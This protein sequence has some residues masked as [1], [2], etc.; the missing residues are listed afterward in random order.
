ME[1]GKTV[2]VTMADLNSRFDGISALVSGDE[3]AAY[4]VIIDGTNR[5]EIKVDATT[6]GGVQGFY[7]TV[8]AADAGK[9]IYFLTMS[10]KG[11][12]SY[13]N[14]TES[15]TVKEAS[16][17]PT[18]SPSPS[19]SPSPVDA[20]PPADTPTISSTS[21]YLSCY[22]NQG[23]AQADVAGYTY[24][25]G[26][27]LQVWANGQMAVDKELSYSSDMYVESVDIP[28]GQATDVS[29]RIK[30]GSKVS[31]WTTESVTP[32]PMEKPA[33]SVTKISAKKASL[34]WTQVGGATHYQIYQGSKLKKTVK[35]GSG[36]AAISGAKAGSAKYKIVP[37]VKNT[38]NPSPVKGPA[39]DTKKGASNQ[40]TFSINKNINSVSYGTNAPFRIS[41]VSLSGSTYTVTGYV[42]NN[43]MFKMTKYKSLKVDI[44]SNG[45]KVAGKTY[46]NKKVNCKKYGVKKLTLKIKGKSGIDLRNTTTS[47][48]TKA[49][50]YWQGIGAKPF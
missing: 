15:L 30:V 31:A 21:S 25:P 46:K 35:Q 14:N 7:Y 16:P 13:N 32:I 23:R 42:V 20:K 19:P 4:W 12:T 3:V 45:K 34:F 28:Y 29:W 36:A 5:Q 24:Q 38:A 17:S 11:E 22:I 48:S 50:S 41:K 9:Q 6:V 18:P 47:W 49:Q 26:V 8:L 40:A 43:R 39:S 1:V 10:T 2:Y 44:Y 27:T 33:L 37:I